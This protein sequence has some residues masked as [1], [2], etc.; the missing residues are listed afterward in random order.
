MLGLASPIRIVPFRG[1]YHLLGARGKDL[2][3]N[4]IYP[5][6]DSRLPFL[7][8]HFT[9]RIDGTVDCGPNA[10]LALSREAYGGG[11]PDPD[12][13]VETLSHPGFLR[14]AWRHLGY[15]VSEMRRSVSKRAL[16]NALQRLV[17]AVTSDDLQPGPVGIR[18]QAVSPQGTLVNDF[19]IEEGS[20][21]VCVLNAPSPAAT[22]SLEIGRLVAA[23]AQ[24]RLNGN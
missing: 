14:L 23:K 10:V 12:D 24:S 16:A 21:V 15:G 4:L 22:A 17:P 6:P 8:V 9:R 18:A 11:M 5:V 19:V 20:H 2:V 7:G 1:E 3:R 13:L